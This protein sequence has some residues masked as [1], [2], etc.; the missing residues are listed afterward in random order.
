MSDQNEGQPTPERKSV[1]GAVKSMPRWKKTLIGLSLVLALVGGGAQIAG[2]IGGRNVTSEATAEAARETPSPPPSASGFVPA[3]GN[4][5]AAAPEAAAPPPSQLQRMAPHLTKIGGSFF[6][7]LVLGVIFRT[8]IK[9]AAMVT[10]AAA[11]LFFVLTYFN[12]LDLDV[13]GMKM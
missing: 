10:V 12:V 8:F 4:E 7:A 2:G 13:A 1:R 6:V 3:G 5:T 11:G 9:T